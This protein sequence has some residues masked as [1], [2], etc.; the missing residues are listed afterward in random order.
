MAAGPDD[1]GNGK[2]KDEDVALTVPGFGS[3]A[4]VA[5]TSGG[6]AWWNSVDTAR[7]AEWVPV[8]TTISCLDLMKA[9]YSGSVMAAASSEAKG[10]GSEL[11]AN[12]GGR[13]NG[14]S[15]SS[16]A[17]VDGLAPHGRQKADDWA[18]PWNG[19]GGGRGGAVSGRGSQWNRLS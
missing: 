18:Y 8:R 4:L 12:G 16:A 17:A 6:D 19:N 1:D 2:A 10:S 3:P 9:K 13:P 15:M 5:G 7:S 11:M 14:T